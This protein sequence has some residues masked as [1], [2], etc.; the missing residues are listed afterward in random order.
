MLQLRVSLEATQSTPGLD[1]EPGAWDE[2][3]GLP[4]SL[5]AQWVSCLLG[6]E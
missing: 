5:L 6:L 3:S 2:S 4:Y 1:G